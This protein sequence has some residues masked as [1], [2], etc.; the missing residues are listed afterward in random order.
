MRIK[1]SVEFSNS[2]LTADEHRAEIARVHQ[3][4]RNTMTTRTQPRFICEIHYLGMSRSRVVRMTMQTTMPGKRRR[5]PPLIRER[6]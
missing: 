1:T 4:Y 3:V 6:S 2:T 5:R